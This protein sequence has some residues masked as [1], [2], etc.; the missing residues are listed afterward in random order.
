[1]KTI[2]SASIAALC[3]PALCLA[4]DNASGESKSFTGNLGIN[5]ATAYIN[6]GVIQNRHGLNYQPYA[7]LSLK[8]HE[9]D[10]I[11][12]KVAFHLGFW[13]NVT[14][15]NSR[16]GNNKI[17]SEFDLIPGV[18]LGMGK[19]TLTE[20]LQLSYFPSNPLL[21]DFCGLQ[22]RLSYDDSDILGALAL[23]PTLTH[24][25]S[26]SGTP[27]FGM[28]AGGHYWHLGVSPSV[29]VG[30][31]TLSLPLGWAVTSGNFY[32][33][34]QN[35]FAYTSAGLDARVNLPFATEAGH[36]TANASLTYY[37]FNTQKTGNPTNADVVGS[38]GVGVAF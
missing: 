3:L 34:N 23:R 37:N 25:A 8:A 16:M 33:T 38:I 10:G 9:G 11:I 13:S 18:S 32:N 4:A 31:V 29:G 14:E 7:N 24:F 5:A 2:L 36:W 1:M 17:W 30:P 6:R 27:G 19:F 21:R 12:D 28:G 26:L 35:G 22:S 15:A 20:S